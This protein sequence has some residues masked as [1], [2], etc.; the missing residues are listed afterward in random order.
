MRRNRNF[1]RRN[2]GPL[3]LFEGEPL[4]G[5]LVQS[6]DPLPIGD[7]A[8]GLGEDPLLLNINFWRMKCR[9]QSSKTKCGKLASM[10]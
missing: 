1:P 9:R 6:K 8:E 10:C 5:P 3:A 7:R 2:I 4:L